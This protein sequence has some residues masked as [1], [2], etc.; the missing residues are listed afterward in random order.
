MLYIYIYISIYIY[1]YNRTKIGG[2]ELVKRQVFPT[3]FSGGLFQV[4]NSTDLR[5]IKY[6]FKLF[7]LYIYIYIYIFIFIL[8]NVQS[9][10]IE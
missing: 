4:L 3:R 2:L 8:I 5:D 9:N 6:I 7:K 10:N 1:I